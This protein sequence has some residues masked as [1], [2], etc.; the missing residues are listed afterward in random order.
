LPG[1]SGK[2]DAFEDH[3]ESTSG[4]FD[5]GSIAEASGKAKS[6]GLKSFEP[7]HETIAFP[8][9][10]FHQGLCP[11]EKDE[12]MSAERI[13]SEFAPN[14]GDEPVEGLPHIDRGSAEGNTSVVR[15][16]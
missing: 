7:D 8:V 11:I 13:G 10:D 4:E 16:G 9:E 2:V 1:Q 12:E 6:A 5:G 3:G 14:E 15:N